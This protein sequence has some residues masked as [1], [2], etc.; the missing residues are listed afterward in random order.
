MRHLLILLILF[1]VCAYSKSSEGESKEVNIA[2]SDKNSEVAMKL[3]SHA[4]GAIKIV[5]SKPISKVILI[6]VMNSRKQL[7]WQIKLGWRPITDI[8]YGKVPHLAVE[9]HRM[10]PVQSFPE[11]GIARN[12]KA[13]ETIILYFEYPK[14]S[15]LMAPGT[16]SEAWEFIVPDSGKEA[17]GRL[18]SS[19]EFP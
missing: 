10:D 4:D 15:L 16:G 17:A 8:Q 12:L 1:S 18:L 13:G 7:I 3:I 9:D 14:D 5:R 11:K 2:E 19:K 6:G